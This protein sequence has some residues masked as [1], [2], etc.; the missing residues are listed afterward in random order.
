MQLF[1]LFLIGFGLYGFR[2]WLR[3]YK[4]PENYRTHMGP[5]G[6]SLYAGGSKEERRKTA[7]WIA[8]C[9]MMAALLSVTIGLYV[10]FAF[11]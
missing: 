6:E 2:Y 8:F 5:W 10:I 7:K 11:E 3:L 9:S 1:G 4:S